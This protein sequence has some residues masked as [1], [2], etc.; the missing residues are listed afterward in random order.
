[1]DEKTDDILVEPAVEA[2]KEPLVRLV[3]NGHAVEMTVG[4]AQALAAEL[5]LVAEQAESEAFVHLYFKDAKD[6]ALAERIVRSMIPA[7]MKHRREQ[8]AKFAADLLRL[9]DTV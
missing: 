5:F 6:K 8:A 2:G 1:M 9:G 4:R 7:M 3:V